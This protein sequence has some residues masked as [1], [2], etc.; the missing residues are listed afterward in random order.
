MATVTRI[1]LSG[2]TNGR[3]IKVAA[4]ATAGTAVH[5]CTS[6]TDAGDG[7][8]I[9]LWAYNDHTASVTLTV[10]FGGTTDPDDLIVATIPPQAGLLYVVP[11]LFLRSTL[12]VAAFAATANVVTVHGYVNKVA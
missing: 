10:E 9:H 12:A 2:S 4:T 8:E 5:T 1:P 6:S 11:G 7:E 3:G